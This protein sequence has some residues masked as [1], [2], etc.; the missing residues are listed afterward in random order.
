LFG[1]RFHGFLLSPPNVRSIPQTEAAS[2][3]CFEDDERRIAFF[4]SK[5]PDAT[6]ATNAEDAIAAASR[7]SYTWYFLDCQIA[8]CWTD[9]N[10]QTAVPFPGVRLARVL[11][12]QPPAHYVIHSLYEAGVNQMYALLNGRNVQVCPFGSFEIELF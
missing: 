1:R 11:A 12:S 8:T 7:Q 3:L 10:G 9:V 2:V 6:Y 4:R 5:L